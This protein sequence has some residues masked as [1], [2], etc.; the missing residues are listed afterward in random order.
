MKLS[1]LSAFLFIASAVMAQSESALTKL[2]EVYSSQVAWEDAG[3]LGYDEE[4]KVVSVKKFRIPVSKN[5]KL[6]FD[7]KKGSNVIF[8]MQNHTS[9]TE[10]TDPAVKKASFEIPFRTRD[11]AVSF[12]TFFNKLIEEQ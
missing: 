8:A 4:A 6:K 10:A 2:K 7:K 3:E 11:G 5:T 9:I 12:I 1:L